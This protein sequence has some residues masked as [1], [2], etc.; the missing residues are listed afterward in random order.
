VAVRLTGSEALGTLTF[1]E[2]TRQ[3][4]PPAAFHLAKRLRA[5]W[6]SGQ[7]GASG[8]TEP[9]SLGL[10]GDY[11]TWA[12]AKAASGGYDSEHILQK[13]LHALR[14]VKSGSAVYERDSVLFDKIEYSWPVL[15]ALMW[16][17]AQRGGHLNVLDVGGSLGSTYFQNRFFLETLH[18]VRWNIV[19]QKRHVDVGRSEFQ[20]ERLRFYETLE[21]CLVETKPDLILLSSVLQYVED[22]YE[23]L[24]KLHLTSCQFLIIDRT[25]F[26]ASTFDRLC[27]QRVPES[28]YEA[29]Y[30]CWIFSKPRFRAILSLHWA[31]MAEF[32]SLDRLSAPVPLE[33]KGLLAICRPS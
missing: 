24:D 16:I 22:P 25:P 3:L 1:R 14:K 19:E 12:E 18:S 6:R 26:S 17:A 4:L 15:S 29:T 27:V 13:T 33:F 7:G 11:A 30:P 20:D 23:L 10:D 21:A 32:D 2:A 31:V 5:R 8:R 28:I 9:S